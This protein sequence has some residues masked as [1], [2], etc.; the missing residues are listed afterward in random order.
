MGHGQAERLEEV[1]EGR[2]Q[3]LIQLLL[4]ALGVTA[5]WSGFMS[6]GSVSSAATRKGV[7][8]EKRTIAV[9]FDGVIHSYINPFNEFQLDPPTEG[10]IEWLHD[11]IEAF[12][13]EI[14]TTRARSAHGATTIRR[15]MDRNG[16][17]NLPITSQKG[18]AIVYLDDRA[19]R[20]EGIFPT[21]KEIF[22]A[23][24]TW[25]RK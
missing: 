1:P 13:V 4:S 10:A 18:M 2:P 20:F 3:C 11:M 23:A 12:N 15:W 25:N 21:A 19:M 22:A 9:D 17:P 14:L 5:T 6:R 24:K 7:V 16:A 8:A